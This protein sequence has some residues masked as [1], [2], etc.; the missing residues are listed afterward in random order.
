MTRTDAD[1]APAPTL[2][3]ILIAGKVV[4]DVVLKFNT[5]ESPP[6][7]MVPLTCRFGEIAPLN[8]HSDAL[9]A[10]PLWSRLRAAGSISY[11]RTAARPLTLI[12]CCVQIANLPLCA[13]SFAATAW[14]CLASRVSSRLTDPICGATAGHI[15]LGTV[16]GVPVL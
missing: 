2:E 12:V 3:S 7:F 10:V 5:I 14:V 8:C 16:T 15:K 6:V 9:D 1:C 13:G 11:Q 4:L